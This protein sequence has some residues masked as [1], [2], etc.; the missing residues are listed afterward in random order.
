MKPPMIPGRQKN[1]EKRGRDRGVHKEA[2]SNGNQDGPKALSV[3]VWACIVLIFALT[4][5]SLAE[6]YL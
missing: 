5:M 4:L 1:G 6:K 3:I 2:G